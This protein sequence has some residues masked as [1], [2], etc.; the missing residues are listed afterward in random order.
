MDPLAQKKIIE[1]EV[2]SGNLVVTTYSTQTLRDLLERI[3]LMPVPCFDDSLGSRIL[4][5]DV[6][7]FL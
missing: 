4:A 2:S 7:Y 5:Q 6:K 1:Y 3:I